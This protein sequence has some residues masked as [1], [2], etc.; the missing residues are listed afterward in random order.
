MA[1]LGVQGRE[2][3]RL[4]FNMNAIYENMTE[5]AEAVAG[6]SLDDEMLSMVQYQHSYNA[7][8]Q[9]LSVIDEMLDTLINGIR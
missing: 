4:E 3:Q 6:V 9:V 5:Q 7:A 8:A 1:D 2:A